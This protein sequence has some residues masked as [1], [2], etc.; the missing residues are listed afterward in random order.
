MQSNIWKFYILSIV[1]NALFMIPVI[2]LFFQ[3][4][5]LTLHQIFL[6]QSIFSLALM[7]FEIPTGYLSDRWGRKNTI[8]S[9]S[10][11]GVIGI[12]VYACSSGFWGFFTAE[13]LLALLVS[14][15]SGTKDAMLYDTLLEINRA[16]EY[17]K[18]T[19]QKRFLGFTSE[20]IASIL[21]GLLATLSL[22][23][24]IW[25]ELIPFGIGFFIALSLKEPVRHKLQEKQHLKA[26]W[27]IT[28][29][30]LCHNVPLRSIDILTSVLSS[31][32]LTLM[33][34]TQP[35][36]IIVG[37]P[38]TLF[39]FTHAGIMMATGFASKCT[40]SIGKRIDN[41]AFLFLISVAV[42]GSYLYVGMVM[43]LWGIVFLL[44]G[45]SMFGFFG[46]IT[47]NMINKM[48]TSDIRATVLSLQSFGERFLFGAIS[49]LVGY[50]ADVYTPNLAILM[51]GIAG[52]IA[53][54][55]IFL[56]VSNTWSLVPD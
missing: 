4:N 36:Q 2:V 30:S 21:G 6:L 9:G 22:R 54:V 13:I 29:S 14:F 15:H 17:L 11:F 39:G 20:A 56:M 25:A 26:M 12:V 48:A 51:T 27:N 43:S 1:Y 38:I 31:L 44:A 8:V 10:I 37:L 18:I 7:I 19:G 16:G 53:L 3:E 47:S 34:F 23:I 33:W 45:R 32:T 50:M 55:V 41:R 5:G 24:T 49:P 46:P 40:H 28:I 42:I 35:Y 52:G